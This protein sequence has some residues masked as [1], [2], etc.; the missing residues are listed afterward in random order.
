MA[1][2]LA[3]DWDQHEARYV[4]ATTAG[5]EVTVNRA[6]SIPLVDVA[7]GGQEARPDLAGSLGAALADVKVGRPVTLVGV[8]RASIELLHLTLPPAKDSEL[9]ELVA[10]QAMRESQSITEESTIDFVPMNRDQKAPRTV[11]AVALSAEELDRIKRTCAA[12]GLK[13]NRL[14]LRPFA[15]FSLFLER[16]KPQEQA[17]LLVNRMVDEADLTLVCEEQV[18]LSR[19]VRL[20]VTADQ[21]QV[22]VRLLIEINRTLMTAPQVQLGGDTVERVY[23]LGGADEHQGLVDRVRAELSLP[24]EVFD[25]FESLSVPSELVPDQRGRFSALLG[26]VL[27]E[28][29]DSHAADFLNP[30]QPPKPPDRRRL[31]AIVAAAVVVLVLAGI[32]H[33]WSELAATE[34]SIRPVKLK[35]QLINEIDTSAKT[36]EQVKLLNAIQAW[37]A[38]NVVWLE[39]LRDLSQRFPS[40]RD[41]IVLRMSMATGRSGGGEIDLQGLVRDPK[42]VVQLEAG[43]RDEY[44]NVRGGGTRQRKTEKDYTWSFDTSI[45]VA[46]R[47]ATTPTSQPSEAV[48]QV[49]KRDVV[50]KASQ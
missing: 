9:P 33:A 47:P 8:E 40:A 15:S 23:I 19:T 35:A 12:V 27:D 6:A 43:V 20:P 36:D 24:V 34:Q 26:M 10:N 17:Y 50:Q 13:P 45:S 37:D 11:T 16:A 21:S 25:P 4:L 14:L 30:R 29:R 49:E 48:A 18:I 41:A 22:A 31:A 3:L 1:R 44:H 28:A 42:I 46:R 2:I 5:E 7:E 39:E 38:R 32:Y